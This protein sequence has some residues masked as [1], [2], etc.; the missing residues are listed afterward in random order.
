MVA[1]DTPL[2]RPSTKVETPSRLRPASLHASSL[3]ELFG[4]DRM[5]AKP[6]C[7]ND[8]QFGTRVMPF[9]IAQGFKNIQ[10]NRPNSV[11][12]LV[13]DIDRAGG[14]D[15]WIGAN[16]PAPNVTMTTPHGK[17]AGRAHIVYVL[18][19]PI[20]NGSEEHQRPSNYVE[21][22]CRAFTMKLSADPD[23][24][25]GLMK[26]PLHPYW[27]TEV[28]HGKT[29]SLAEL[30][31]Y[32]ELKGIQRGH[33]LVT[34]LGRNRTLFD[35][36]RTWAYRQKLDF[37]L[38]GAGYDMFAQAVEAEAH[39]RNRFLDADQLPWKEVHNTSKSISKWTWKKYTGSGITT[40]EFILAQSERGSKKGATKREAG[41]ALLRAGATV[42]DIVQEFGVGL[43]TAY[44]WAKIILNANTEAKYEVLD[45]SGIAS[46]NFLNTI[47]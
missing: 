34:G 26:N 40:T 10:P 11:Q 2:T 19:D 43:A 30:H 32:V 36:L 44:R 5:P 14:A 47:R 27:I 29:Y 23:Y 37:Q 39:A 35:H 9:A 4:P 28:L 7:T 24:N 33:T 31:E 42:E 15:A 16:L 41:L 6:R 22:I 13:F 20:Y 1:T 46:D 25:G 21:A 38:I 12:Y 45:T 3:L 18:K 17:R 8:V